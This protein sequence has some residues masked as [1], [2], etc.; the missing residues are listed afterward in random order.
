MNTHRCQ[1][2]SLGHLTVPDPVYGDFRLAVFPF[3]HDGRTPLD[4]PDGFGLWTETLRAI[5]RRVPVQADATQFFVT[6]DSKFFTTPGYLRREGIHMDGN[7][8]VDPTFTYRTWGNPP[9]WADMVR[10]ADE[11]KPNNA[12]V[13]LGF[14]LP[15]DIQV[16]VGKYVSGDLGG[17]LTASS[18]T[19]CQAWPGTYSGEV[20]PG[21]DW[22]DMLTQLEGPTVLEAHQLWLM[23]SNCP[24]ET[25]LIPEGARRT[26]LRITLPHN[27]RNAA[28][29]TSSLFSHQEPAQWF[30]IEIE[31][32][33]EPT[34]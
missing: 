10:I 19:G 11:V 3:T 9:T 23:S 17:I 30:G 26:F 15:Y 32:V 1:L 33:P 8:C 25:M 18:Y 7:F 34:P 4:L 24:H 22:A 31:P 5:M 16:P 13:K 12:H 14:T 21:G 28:L 27:Y 6:I 20:G 29:M 2:L